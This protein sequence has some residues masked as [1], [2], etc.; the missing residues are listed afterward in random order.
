MTQD[1]VASCRH[2]YFHDLFVTYLLPLILL[3][4]RAAIGCFIGNHC[5]NVLVVYADDIVLAFSWREFQRLPDLLLI[6]TL[7]IDLSCNINK[8]V[9]MRFMPKKRNCMY[10]TVFPRFRLGVSLVLSSSNWGIL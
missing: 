2:I 8:T 4:N 10:G 7:I 9:C 5:F 6:Q 3:F 1:K